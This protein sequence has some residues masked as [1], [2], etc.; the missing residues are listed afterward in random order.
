MVVRDGTRVSS[1]TRTKRARGDSDRSEAT[2]AGERAATAA[3]ATWR[4]E[5]ESIR[6]DDARR[7]ASSS[8]VQWRSGREAK[9]RRVCY[10]EKS[11][12]V[13]ATTDPR[14][15]SRFHRSAYLEGQLCLPL[16]GAVACHLRNPSRRR[17]ERLS[18]CD[19]ER[20]IMMM[21]G[22][23]EPSSSHFPVAPR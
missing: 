21:D 7:T 11:R 14:R 6:V 13:A 19:E 3:G 17:M 12:A 4:R 5:R 10:A 2:R 15:V 22:L 16:V 23:L 20:A 8:P 9:R 1:P 18:E